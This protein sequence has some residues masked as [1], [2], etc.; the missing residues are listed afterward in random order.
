MTA[1]TVVITAFTAAWAW[2]VTRLARKDKPVTIEGQCTVISRQSPIDPNDMR[3]VIRHTS[4]DEVAVTPLYLSQADWID[5]EQWVISHLDISW[6]NQW[7]L[8]VPIHAYDRMRGA[9]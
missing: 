4:T 6:S 7:R 2:I 5:V 9:K 1:I 8:Y 3:V